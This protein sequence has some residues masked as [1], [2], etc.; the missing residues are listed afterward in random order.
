MSWV[1]Q[2][3]LLSAQ[4]NW[5]YVCCDT[6]SLCTGTVRQPRTTDISCRNMKLC[7]HSTAVFTCVGWMLVTLLN[8][9]HTSQCLSH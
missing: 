2:K 6:S 1:I 7:L 5:L 4:N 9:S 8:V 3:M